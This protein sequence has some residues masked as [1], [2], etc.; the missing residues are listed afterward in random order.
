M[1]KE[2]FEEDIIQTV[3]N[4]ILKELHSIDFTRLDHKDK[5][6]IPPEFIKMIWDSIKWSEVVEE[7]RPKIQT[8]ICNTVIGSMETELKT[9]IKKLLSVDGVREKLRMEVYPQL[10]KV[11]DDSNE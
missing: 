7:I 6:V 4:K 3:K 8:R 1:S 10:M 5:K 11:L 2:N 9:D